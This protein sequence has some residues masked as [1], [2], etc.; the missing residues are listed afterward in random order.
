M[1][2]DHTN[3]TALR[4][5]SEATTATALDLLRA[6]AAA[7]AQRTNQDHRVFHL[8]TAAA[9]QNTAVVWAAREALV[10]ATL[11]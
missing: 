10:L 5:I 4:L 1:K 3:N 8:I 11:A 7:Q 6:L 9:A 2:S